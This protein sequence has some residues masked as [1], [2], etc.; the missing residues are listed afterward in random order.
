MLIPA[1][2][3]DFAAHA[4]GTASVDE[5]NCLRYGPTF[6]AARASF[7]L[8]SALMSAED[9]GSTGHSTNRSPM[10]RCADALEDRRSTTLEDLTH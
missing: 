5:A 4:A 9:K 3:E 6:V 7:A 1:S 10:S 2:V 8:G